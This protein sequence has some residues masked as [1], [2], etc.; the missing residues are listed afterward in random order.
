ASARVNATE[1][2]P[3]HRL[4]FWRGSRTNDAVSS[5]VSV[6]FIGARGL[7]EGRD[8][9][10]SIAGTGT[11][12]DAMLGADKAGM[13]GEALWFQSVDSARRHADR[14]GDISREH[15]CVTRPPPD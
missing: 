1:R 12:R 4:L 6:D 5:V 7:P 10:R 14:D 15:W 2:L 13:T 9:Q 3:S 8:K 11:E